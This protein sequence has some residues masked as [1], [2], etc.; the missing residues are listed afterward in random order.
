[1]NKIT[2]VSWKPSS[3]SIKSP[4]FK[5]QEPQAFDYDSFGQSSDI[6]NSEIRK[7]VMVEGTPF[8]KI[9]I[10][11]DDDLDYYK[12]MEDQNEGIESGSIDERDKFQTP[13]PPQRNE[14]YLNSNNC[15]D[16]ESFHPLDQRSELSQKYEEERSQNTPKNSE[17]KKK[18]AKKND[19]KKKRKQRHA[20]LENAGDFKNKIFN[21]PALLNQKRRKKGKKKNKAHHSTN[22]RASGLFNSKPKKKKNSQ[23]DNKMVGPFEGFAY[24]QKDRRKQS[25]GGRFTNIKKLR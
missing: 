11:E 7:N 4:G 8:Q 21:G 10:D 25:I 9:V 6:E 17:K 15:L 13:I 19:H 23:N 5:S 16:Y 12:S 14:D 3:P 2:P 18:Y 20:G 22:K 1:M 24:S